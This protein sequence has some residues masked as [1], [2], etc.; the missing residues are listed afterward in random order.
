MLACGSKLFISFC[1][2][3][4]YSD[5]LPCK[6]KISYSLTEKIQTV[7]KRANMSSP[8]EVGSAFYQNVKSSQ[9]CTFC[10]YFGN[11]GRDYT[12]RNLFYTFKRLN[13]LIML[14]K[15]IIEIQRKI[16]FFT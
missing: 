12:Y 8:Q 10:T 6:K 2:D 3:N 11:I 16:K 1:K 4:K 15:I 7:T 13:S 9:K 14:I 5:T